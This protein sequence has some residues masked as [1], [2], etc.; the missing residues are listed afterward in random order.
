MCVGPLT[1]SATGGRWAQAAVQSKGQRGF[2]VGTLIVAE[3]ARRAP[4][5]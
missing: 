1:R 4:L 2:A 5:R 3:E